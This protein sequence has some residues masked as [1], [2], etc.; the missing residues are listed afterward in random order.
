MW[1]LQIHIAYFVLMHL[2]VGHGPFNW[3]PSPSFN[4]FAKGHSSANGWFVSYSSSNR[5]HDIQKSGTAFLKFIGRNPILCSS[6]S[7][8]AQTQAQTRTY[9]GGG[10]A[11]RDSGSAVSNTVDG[12]ILW[13]APFCGNGLLWEV[14]DNKPTHMP[15]NVAGAGV[16]WRVPPGAVAELALA[17]LSPARPRQHPAS[18]RQRPSQWCPATWPGGWRRRGG[19]TSRCVCLM[20]FSGRQ[21]EDG[22]SSIEV[23]D[24]GLLWKIE[25]RWFFIYWFLG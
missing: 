10:I 3:Q 14:N 5:H 20:D 21:R 13:T 9:S 23:N 25:G 2:V 12:A 11:T 8:Q 17:D 19:R 24:N 6:V 16:G 4:F 22:F 15:Q 18:T 1:G 7:A